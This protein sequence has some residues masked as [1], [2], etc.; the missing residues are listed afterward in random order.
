LIYKTHTYGMANEYAEHVRESGWLNGEQMLTPAYRYRAR[1]LRVIDGDTY[2][3]AIDLGLKVWTHVP[4]RLFGWSCP[5]LNE[6]NG[7]AAKAA[8]EQYLLSAMAIIIETE[9]DKQTFARWLG[10]V[11]CDGENIGAKLEA[12][13]FAS[14]ATSLP[15]L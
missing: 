2:E 15:L 4:I 10:H 12:V 9:K 6:P 11:Y 1:P 14:R 7:L 5:E 13:G 3:M 8:A